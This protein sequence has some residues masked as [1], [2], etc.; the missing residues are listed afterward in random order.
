MT[1]NVIEYNVNQD[2]NPDFRAEGEKGE[3]PT[4]FLIG[5][6]RGAG[7][8]SGFESWMSD[9]MIEPSYLR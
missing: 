7:K 2:S 4:S 6:R 1:C 3:V 5:E 8:L 9:L